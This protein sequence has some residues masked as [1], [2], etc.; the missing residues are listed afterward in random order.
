MSGSI[1]AP[2][3]SKISLGTIGNGVAG[4]LFERELKA[5]LENISDVTTPW[6]QKRRL[7]LEFTFYP[8][9][10]RDSAAIEIECNKKIPTVSPKLTD[11][12]IDEDDQGELV[13]VQEDPKQPMLDLKPRRIKKSE[14][15]ELQ[16]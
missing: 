3:L 4:E 8:D 15:L 7:T 11:I 2:K 12:Y 5:V 1:K 14:S 10:S 13:A 6:K 16:Q 9:E